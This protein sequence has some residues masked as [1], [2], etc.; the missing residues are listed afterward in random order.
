M[1]RIATR[2]NQR[3]A[4]KLVKIVIQ[5][6]QHS[7][8]NKMTLLR[9]LIPLALSATFTAKFIHSCEEN[10]SQSYSSAQWALSLSRQRT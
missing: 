8:K 5:A 7:Q 6:L 2:S 9:C 4:S 3:P 10:S 1:G